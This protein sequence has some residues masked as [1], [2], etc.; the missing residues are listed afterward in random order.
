MNAKEGRK[1]IMQFVRTEDLKVGMRLARP[2]YNRNGVLLYERDS[3]LTTQGIISIRNFGL[4]GMFILEPA[5]PVPPMTAEDIEFERFQT[6]SVFAIQE[7]MM[8]ILQTK[9]AQKIQMIVTSIIKSYGQLDHKINFIQN[10]RSKEDFI[11][12]HALNV[13]ILTAMISRV[14]HLNAEEQVDTV[15]AAI[16]HDIGKLDGAMHLLDKQELSEQDEVVMHN[17]LLNSYDMIDEIF[18]ATPNVKRICVQ[19]L[20]GLESLSDKQE[21]EEKDLKISLAA[22]ILMVAEVFDEM[23]AMQF[24][25]SPESPVKALHF[26]M[27]HEELFDKKVVQALIKSIHIL[28]PGVCVELNTGETGLVIADNHD[29]VFRP[30]ILTFRDNEVM[31]LSNEKVYADIEITDIMRTLDNRYVMDLDSLKEKGFY[32]G[33]TFGIVE[34]KAE[35]K[36]DAIDIEKKDIDDVQ[37][38]VPGAD[39]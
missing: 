12:K 38:Y 31:E 36:V 20:K 30:M 39:I 37:E 23:T 7:E 32:D 28:S 3:K 26:L 18:A 1:S 35:F 17:A 27:E 33:K 16:I 19:C 11:Y 22:R 21:S 13:A 8:R 9:K 6:M 24:G 5:E 15:T 34:S 4:I 2:I 14:L 29:D 10:L 25:K